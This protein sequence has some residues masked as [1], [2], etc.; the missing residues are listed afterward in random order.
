[1]D[2]MRI[3]AA[4]IKQKGFTPT[5]SGNLTRKPRKIGDQIK[6][7]V[8]K[9]LTIGVP[10]VAGFKVGYD[11]GLKKNIKDIFKDFNPTPELISSSAYSARNVS[12]SMKDS[13]E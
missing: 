11:K 4:K 10:A 13:R 2:K 1:R 9:G 8:K 3:A 12:S 5:K 6:S 7:G